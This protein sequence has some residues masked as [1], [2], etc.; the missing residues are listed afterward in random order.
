MTNQV[1][2]FEFLLLAFPL[3]ITF[4]GFPLLFFPFYEELDLGVF[5][6]D[7]FYLFEIGY[8]L[9]FLLSKGGFPFSKRGFK[10]FSVEFACFNVFLEVDFLSGERPNS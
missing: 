7:L 2:F 6:L 8:V 3:L 4:G 9:P 10:K 1:F 5:W